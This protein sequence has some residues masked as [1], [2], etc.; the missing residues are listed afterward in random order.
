MDA[1][2]GEVGIRYG[3]AII[4][5]T[6]V[7]DR[8]AGINDGFQE[9]FQF[10]RGSQNGLLPEDREEAFGVNLEVFIPNANVGLFTRYG[11][12]NNLDLGRGGD[13]YNVGLNVLDL[14]APSDRFGIA[15]G[16][17]LSNDELRRQEGS[18]RPDAFEV[19]YDFQFLSNLR[20]GFNVQAL[21]EFS[22]I[23]LGFRIK[24]EFDMIPFR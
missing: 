7:T 22:E 13:T 21:D 11:R 5:G 24:T 15:Y 17:A 3:N 19:L 2:A 23:I 18:L 20:L 9:I 1:W 6:Y 10:D 8:D 14:F 16:R 12:Y 4:R